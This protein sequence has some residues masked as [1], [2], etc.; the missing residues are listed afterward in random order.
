MRSWC[1]SFRIGLFVSLRRDYFPF[2]TLSQEKALRSRIIKI[3][4]HQ[5]P[6][7]R[8]EWRNQNKSWNEFFVEQHSGAT[9]WRVYLNRF[10]SF[11][12]CCGSPCSLP[13]Y[14]STSLFL[15][16]ICVFDQAS[17]SCVSAAHVTSI[18]NMWF[19]WYSVDQKWFAKDRRI[20]LDW[21]LNDITG[22]QKDVISANNISLTSMTGD[23]GTDNVIVS[24]KEKDGREE[25]VW[26][27]FSA[28][29][30]VGTK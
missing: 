2:I 25:M 29:L 8:V 19:L 24:Q 7:R 30:A 21:R 15:G 12:E 11:H 28:R 16:A 3:Q 18:S 6:S 1:C 13:W 26:S 22:A 27:G 9:R 4:R 17:L 23:I 14:P 20:V 5:S 10:D